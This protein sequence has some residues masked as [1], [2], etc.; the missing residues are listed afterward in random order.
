MHPEAHQLCTYPYNM[1]FNRLGSSTIIYCALWTG[2]L[3][4]AFSMETELCHPDNSSRYCVC[5]IRFCKT[6]LDLQFGYVWVLFYVEG[7]SLLLKAGI[8]LSFLYNYRSLLSKQ[9]LMFSSFIRALPSAALMTL[10]GSLS[11]LGHFLTVS[12]IFF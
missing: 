7:I 12:K 11:D 6:L 8:S 2:K 4:G 3:T 1:Q 5:I 10:Q 9:V